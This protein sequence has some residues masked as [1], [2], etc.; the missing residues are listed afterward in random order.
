MPCRAVCFCLLD[1]GLL[2][3]LVAVRCG[4]LWWTTRRPHV[5]HKRNP[6]L[7][8]TETRTIIV[9]ARKRLQTGFKHCAWY[10]ALCPRR[11]SFDFPCKPVLARK[12]TSS[13]TLHLS[14]LNVRAGPAVEVHVQVEG[15]GDARASA[16]S[17]GRVG[18]HLARKP[19]CVRTHTTTYI[20]TVKQ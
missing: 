16:V 11:G 17:L 20:R 7:S 12:S 3:A 10:T 6:G 2:F 14:K 18:R 8:E 13:T 15:P 9:Q 19:D 4:A 1:V 5:Q